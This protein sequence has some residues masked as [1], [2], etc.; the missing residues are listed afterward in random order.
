MPIVG[1]PDGTQVSFPDE[2]PPEQ[3]KSFIAQKF[4]H[5]ATPARDSIGAV[6]GE[7]LSNVP[8]S[9]AEFGKNM[10]QPI[11]HPIDTATSLKDL[12][13]GVLQKLG[14]ASGDEHVQNAD[15]V[16][17]FLMNRYGG[18]NEIV[19][20]LATDPV[21]LAADLSMILTGGGSLAARLPGIAGKVGE[22]AAMAGRVVDPLNV[23]IGAAKVAGKTASSVL[24]V[25]TGAGGKA[26]ETAASAG[27]EGGQ[28]AKAFRDSF[29]GKAPLEE[30]VADAKNAVQQLRQQR[31]TEY[32]AAMKMVGD[33]KVVLDFDKIL[34][35]VDKTEKVKTYK[36]QSLSPSTEAIR[37]KITNAT[38][39]WSLL[40]PKN[41]HTAEGLDALKQ[42]IGDIRDATQYGTPE[43]VVADQIY[44]TIRQTIVDQVPEYGKIMKGY[45]EA[46][47][48]IKEIEGTL[49][50]K[51]GARVDTSLRKLQSV[52]RD[53]VNTNY[54]QR[55]V[56]AN[57]LVS[58]GAPNLIEKLAGQSLSKWTPRGLGP[59]VTLGAEG[60]IGGAAASAG[61]LGA[62]AKLLP[63]LAAASP[64]IVGGAAYGLGTAARPFA[65]LPLR[66]GANASFQIGRTSLQ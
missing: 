44:R 64:K 39:E 48:I 57:Y 47:S 12:G 6:A 13:L 53:N 49:S 50:L 59:L 37:D 56:L 60:G 14:L 36:G 35:A 43:R 18:K 52:L 17:K 27:M 29:T 65:D 15:A 20:T 9:A 7:A 23:P 16:G 31:G 11:L 46:S 51:P 42:K 38:L 62:I 19:N 4:P 41:F 26:I 2:M 25:T 55:E 1:M 22:A 54:G 24:G 66:A 58:A 3:I 32:R 45:E 8:S 30:V 40:D 33:D 5:V 63:A 61:G 28:A 10:V 21:G 34:D